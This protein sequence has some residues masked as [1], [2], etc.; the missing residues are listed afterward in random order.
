MAADLASEF[1]AGLED[2]RVRLVLGLPDSLLKSV[3]RALAGDPALRYVAVTNEGEMPGIAAGAYLGGARSVMV[4][5]NSG[6]RQA[7]EPLA[8]FALTHQVP[9]VVVMPYRGDLGERQW[10][11]HS[12]AQTMTPLLDALRIPYWF[13]SKLP[14]MR[15][16]L[17]A[18]WD[19]AESSQLPVA[20]ILR[21][22]CVDAAA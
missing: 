3:H 17:P 2:A 20:L 13:V 10:W 14:E 1:A 21:D 6:I 7:C 18:A 5:E 4:M 15:P 12:H 16:A 9:M 8:R 19:H 11:G 22:E